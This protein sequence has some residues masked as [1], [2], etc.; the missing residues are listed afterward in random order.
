MKTASCL[1]PG[2]LISFFIGLAANAQEWEPPR[3]AHGKPDLQG[4]WTNKTLTPLTRNQEFGEQQALTAEQVARLE[5]GHQQYLDAEYADSDP[6]RGA[7]FGAQAGDDGDTNDGYN[8][9]W[10]DLG[11][12]IQVVKG[13]YRSS[14]I[15]DPPDG[16]IPYAGDPRARFRRDPNG[17][18][19]YDGPEGRPLAERCLLSFGSHSGPPML[20]VMYN[21]NYQFVQTEDYILIL[22][23]MAHDARII[24][25]DDSEHL[26]GMKKWMGD[27]VGR[28]EEDTLI[29]ETRGFNPQQNFRGASE[30]LRVIERFS[31]ISES[32]ILYSFTVEDSTVFSQPFS[33]ELVFNARPNTESMYEYA[34]HEGNYALSGILAGARELERQAATTEQ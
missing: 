32:E 4:V 27:S 28:W 11:T 2:I 13:E 21:N 18:G 17:P 22:A 8:E 14:I 33:G 1:V 30:N 31:R 5:A 24:R 9:F 16:Q 19:P 26:L 34:C 10:K 29:V 25:L 3:T 7:G 15:V 12:R 20:P 23:E 6:D